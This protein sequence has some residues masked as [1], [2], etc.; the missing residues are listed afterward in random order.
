MQ[1]WLRFFFFNVQQHKGETTISGHVLIVDFSWGSG[2]EQWGQ[3]VPFGETLRTLL[4]FLID[5]R[6][7]LI[8]VLGSQDLEAICLRIPVVILAE[9]ESLLGFSLLSSV[10]WSFTDW[11]HPK[12]VRLKQEDLG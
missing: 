3:N 11:L 1:L 12:T 9:L 7:S 10:L 2:Q 8:V 4:T 6:K 5:Q